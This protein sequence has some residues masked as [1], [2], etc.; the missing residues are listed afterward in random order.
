MLLREVLQRHPP[1]GSMGLIQVLFENLPCVLL[2]FDFDLGLEI[3]QRE[4]QGPR[5]RLGRASGPILGHWAGLGL[6]EGQRLNLALPGSILLFLAILGLVIGLLG[7]LL[8]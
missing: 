4:A 3:G 6:A 5:L 7:L 8:I 2:G 1:V